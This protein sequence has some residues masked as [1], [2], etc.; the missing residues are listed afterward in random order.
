MFFNEIGM[1]YF[2][3]GREAKTEY[4]FQLSLTK[5]RKAHFAPAINNL[6]VLKL[7]NRHYQEALSLFKQAAKK[8]GSIISPL[9]NMAQIYLEFNLAD[10]ALPILVSLNKKGSGDPDILLS[11]ANVYLLKGQTNEALKMI[12]SIP[13]NF[14]KR[15]DVG[16]ARAIAL[17]ES[18]QYNEAK[19]LLAEQQFGRYLPIKRSARRLQKLVNKKI[20]EIERLQKAIEEKKEAASKRVVASKK[21]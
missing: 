18:K 4:Y 13:S 21:D 16:L 9:F 20:E 5:A 14:S 12:N 2:L 6:G 1:C 17:F 19:E 11:L 3:G 8:G 15:D 7:K 10:A